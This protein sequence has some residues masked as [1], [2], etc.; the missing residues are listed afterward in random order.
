MRLSRGPFEALFDG[1]DWRWHAPDRHGAPFHRGA[2]GANGRAPCVVE[3]GA[4]P[5][6]STPDGRAPRTER[7]VHRVA[8]REAQRH[9][10]GASRPWNAGKC[11]PEEG[12]EMQ[13]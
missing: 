4:F 2:Q 10:L 12:L 11:E 6:I 1:V 13:V 7:A 5:R 8:H 9:R 3:D